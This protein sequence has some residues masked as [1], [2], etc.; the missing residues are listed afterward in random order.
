MCSS[1]SSELLND[2]IFFQSPS[3]GILSAMQDR[4]IIMG[5]GMLVFQSPSRGILSAMVIMLMRSSRRRG[6]SFNPHLGEFFLQFFGLQKMAQLQFIVSFNPHL[7]EF[8]LQ[9][10]AYYMPQFK[11]RWTFNP[12][13]GEF[14]LQ[15][16][17]K[18][19]VVFREQEELSIPIQGNSFCNLTP[20]SRF[21]SCIPTFNPH[22]GEFFLQSKKVWLESEDV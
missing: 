21:A 6:I 8:F 10:T 19:L 1:E 3:R 15:F 14:F 18:D 20:T 22:L 16:I 11:L 2:F 9:Q 17:C 7:G 13:L 4:D 12:H 5:L